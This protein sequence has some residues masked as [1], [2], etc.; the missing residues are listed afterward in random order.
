MKITLC[1]H[2]QHR[3]S[4]SS[5]DKLLNV[6]T[7]KSQTNIIFFMCLSFVKCYS[8]LMLPVWQ[9]S[10][11]FIEGLGWRIENILYIIPW[12]CY[13]IVTYNQY[14][15][16]RVNIVNPIHIQ[17]VVMPLIMATVREVH[18]SSG[19]KLIWNLCLR[20]RDETATVWCEGLNVS[21]RSFCLRFNSCLALDLALNH[22]HLF[23]LLSA[24]PKKDRLERPPLS[25]L[26]CPSLPSPLPLWFFRALGCWSWLTSPS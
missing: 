10:A 16:V 17:A 21:L 22:N 18:I 6:S 19:S 24:L 4:H 14:V 15:I 9:N 11:H 5:S 23:Q 25:P 8:I 13:R 1:I 2:E 7:S 20:L 12:L 3:K 26:S